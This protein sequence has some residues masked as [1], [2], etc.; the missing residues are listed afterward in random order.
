MRKLVSTFVVS[1]ALVAGG[2]AATAQDKPTETKKPDG[3]CCEGEAA[4]APAG[5]PVK[6]DGGCCE[7]EAA[8]AKAKQGGCDEAKGGC[9][10]GEAAMA[11]LGCLDGLVGDWVGAD[12]NKDG[13]PDV[14]VTYRKTAGGTAL[15]ETLMPGTPKEMITVYTKT[16]DGWMLT[17]Y[18]LGNQPRMYAKAGATPNTLTFELCAEGSTN[19]TIADQHMHSL[20]MTMTDA[21]HIKQEWTMWK[22]GKEGGKIAFSLTR[23]PAAASGTK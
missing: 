13:Q 12:E 16:K 17:H 6:Q 7:G 22:D 18:C 2:L 23:K 4:K 15:V 1:L 8:A 9:C 11:S 21:N 20:V 5:A 10:E 19:M 3:G 14:T